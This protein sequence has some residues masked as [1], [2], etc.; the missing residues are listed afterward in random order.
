MVPL[1]DINEIN[2]QVAVYASQLGDGLSNFI[3][4]T[5]GALIAILSVAG[6]PYKK[7]IRFFGPLFLIF[8]AISITM[9]VIAQGFGYGPF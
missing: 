4:P 3:Y 9:I 6:I 2:R 5:N 8:A 1:A 7:W